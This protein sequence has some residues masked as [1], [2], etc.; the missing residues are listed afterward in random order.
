[1]YE[2]DDGL[3]VSLSV[4]LCLCQSL[5]NGSNTDVN[6][7]LWQG[8]LPCP[9]CRAANCHRPRHFSCCLANCRN[10]VT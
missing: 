9:S 2:T 8:L 5:L 3:Q 1:V 7:S 6:F 10:R 4:L